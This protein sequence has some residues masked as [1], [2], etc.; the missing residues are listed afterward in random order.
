MGRFAGLYLLILERPELDLTEHMITQLFH[1]TYFVYTNLFICV[2]RFQSQ[3]YLISIIGLASCQFYL[4]IH[5]INIDRNFFV[6][7]CGKYALFGKDNACHFYIVICLHC[8][9]DLAFIY[10]PTNKSKKEK[11]CHT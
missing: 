1:T 6:P 8:P 5:S 2:L 11:V 7:S 10:G 4:I 9:Q 3:S